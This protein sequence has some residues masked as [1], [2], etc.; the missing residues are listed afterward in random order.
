[1][2]NMKKYKLTKKRLARSPN[3]QKFKKLVR[4]GAHPRQS[5]LDAR[6]K[7]YG[8]LLEIARKR[9]ANPAGFRKPG[10][11]NQHK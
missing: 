8:E 7:G 5:D 11:L 4:V 10:S 9:G 3:H 6:V 1:M 2:A